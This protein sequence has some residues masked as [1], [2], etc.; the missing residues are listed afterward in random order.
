[1]NLP[2]WTLIPAIFVLTLIYLGL[3]IS[4]HWNYSQQEFILGNIFIS[5]LVGII[6]ISEGIYL[7]IKERK[8]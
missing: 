6:Y 1:M 7:K 3:G 8:S 5:L 4:G 2:L